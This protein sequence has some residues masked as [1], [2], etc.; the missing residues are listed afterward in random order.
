MKYLTTY[1]QMTLQDMAKDNAMGGLARTLQHSLKSI[2]RHSLT[3]KGTSSMPSGKVAGSSHPQMKNVV[4]QLRLLG[5]LF[6][7]ASRK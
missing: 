1:L 7:T 5:C 6:R 4:W 2:A 3:A